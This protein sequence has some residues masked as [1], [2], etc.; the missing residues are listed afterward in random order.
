MQMQSYMAL[1]P[2]MRHKF[3]SNLNESSNYKLWQLATTH[4]RIPEGVRRE[5]TRI[6]ESR[7]TPDPE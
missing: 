7:G 4:L 5:A 1:E 6:L 2:F 3:Y